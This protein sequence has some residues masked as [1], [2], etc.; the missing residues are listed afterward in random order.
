MPASDAASPM[1]EIDG[2][3]YSGSGTIVR[4]AVV[5]AALTGTPVHVANARVRRL[6]PG[7]Q[8]QHVHVIEA[9]CELVHGRT[10]GVCR[11]SREFRFWPDSVQAGVA[12]YTWDIGSA[13]SSTLLALTALPVMMFGSHPIAAEIRGGVFQDFAP[14]FFHVRDV[15]LPLLRRMGVQ[16]EIEMQRPGYVPI[17]GGIL[18]LRAK[19]VAALQSI[20]REQQ[21]TLEGFSGI[22][23]ASHLEERRVAQRMADAARR[24]LRGSGQD[25]EID[26]IE[27]Q[28]ALQ[29]GAALAMFANFD[30]GWRLGSDWAGAPHRPAEAIGERVA[31]QLL[32]DVNSSATLDTFA[33]DQIILF[34]ALARG[35]SRFRIPRVTE[36]IQSNAWL[37]N[38]FLHARADVSERNL[39]I[40]G[41]GFQSANYQSAGDNGPTVG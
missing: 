36:H 13:G 28:S 41:A 15:M 20:V 40:E 27:E 9:I 14:S 31:R 30:G 16:A 35:V 34:S 26:L 17:G 11:G 5:L 37:V 22:A 3:R 1:V 2:S 10:E 25:A 19:P 38:E 6:K 23:L 7:L 39:S 24:V 4:Q 18:R 32:E 21:G 12:E 33:A 8:P 29:R